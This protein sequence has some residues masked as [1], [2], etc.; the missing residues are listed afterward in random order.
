MCMIIKYL[1]L[2]PVR[3]RGKA[4]DGRCIFRNHDVSMVEEVAV[5]GGVVGSEEK[6]Q[7]VRCGAAEA[8]AALAEA[9]VGGD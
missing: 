7:A 8:T 9:T 2:G 3:V 6:R 5:I 1:N 4:G